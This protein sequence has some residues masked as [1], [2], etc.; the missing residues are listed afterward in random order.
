MNKVALIFLG[1]IAA[2][3]K[4]ALDGYGDGKSNVKFRPERCLRTQ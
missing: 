3:R 2:L 4:S 1:V